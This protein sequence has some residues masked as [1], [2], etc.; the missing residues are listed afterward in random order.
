MSSIWTD[1][2]NLLVPWNIS[3]VLVLWNIS[4]VLVLWNQPFYCL[5][6]AP[7]S[8]GRIS[9]PPST[10]KTVLPPVSKDWLNIN[11]FVFGSWII[12]ELMSLRKCCTV[13]YDTV[14]YIT[15]RC[16]TVQ[17]NYVWLV[18]FN[19]TIWFWDVLQRHLIQTWLYSEWIPQYC[20]YMYE[21]EYCW[22][23]VWF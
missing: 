4:K 20:I 19:R 5:K 9:N 10:Q 17:Y 2:S 6:S 1:F 18:L 12:N 14:W 3:K 23:I 11:F 22:K 8:P 15:L 16:S 7:L 13:Q 21:I